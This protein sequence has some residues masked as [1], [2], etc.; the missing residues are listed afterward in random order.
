[1]ELRSR[2]RLSGLSINGDGE[3]GESGSCNEEDGNNYMGAG[4]GGGGSDDEFYVLSSDS[5]DNSFGEMTEEMG[6]LLLNHQAKATIGVHDWQGPVNEQQPAEQSTESQK[7]KY[8]KTNKRRK[9]RSGELLMWEVWEEGHDKWIN[10]NLT[11]DVDFDHH[12]GLE[13]TTAEAPSD[14]IMPLLR[15]QKEWLAWALEQEESST[16]G[17]I[18][19]D[20]MGMGKTIQAIALVLAK[21]E[22][23]QNS[24]EF[25]GPSPIPGSSS[26]LAGI[27]ATL[28]VCPVVAV[29]QWVSEIDRYTTKGSTKVLVYHGANREKSSKLFHDYD[30]VITTYSIIESEFR[31][32][33][34]P[35]K[36]KCVYCGNSFYEKKLTV[37][38]KYFC[39]PD[40]NRTA[41]QSKQAKKKLKTVP[42]ASKQKTES[43]KDKSRPMELSEV[44]LGLQ[45]EKSLLHS[46]KWERIILDEAHFIKD[47]RCNT[48]KAVFALHSSYKWALSGTPLQNRVGE[49]YSLVRFLQIVPYSYYLCKD[50]DCRTL[51]YGSTTQCSSCPHSS[52]RHFC[53]WNKYVSNPIQKHGNA[54]YGRRAMILL[55]HKVLKN[56]VLRRTKK[57]GGLLI[58]LFLLELLY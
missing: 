37:H 20:E 50:C 29:T 43:D 51:D 49:L 31:K 8:Y 36:K 24:F 56:I 53:W 44:E 23:H 17:G 38:L 7:K 9:K 21:R 12:R 5:D 19:A 30:F 10:E 41:K 2:R 58:L 6:D 35:P 54:D 18:L 4:G 57:K 42:S 28:V 3:H 25:N 16:R 11:E 40:A 46:L 13:A 48:A 34:M 15:F 33:M 55:K 32:Y 39:G 52:V 47:R 26:D 1:M 14:L 45:K 27:K 22:F